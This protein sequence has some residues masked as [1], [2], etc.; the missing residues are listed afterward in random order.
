VSHPAKPP[1]PIVEVDW[2]DSTG[3]SGWSTRSEYQTAL[4]DEKMR[5]HTT[6]YL[7]SKHKDY[8]AI[9]Q[10]WGETTDRVN[11][12]LQIPRGAITAIRVLHKGGRQ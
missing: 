6:G 9:A 12:V 5:Q 7:F 10:S 8:V 1:G 4:D 11:G 3:H 2:V